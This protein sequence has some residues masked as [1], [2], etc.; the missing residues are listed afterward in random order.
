M[1]NMKAWEAQRRDQCDRCAQRR[2]LHV[3]WPYRRARALW[4]K[5]M[6]AALYDDEKF[7]KEWVGEPLLVLYSGTEPYRVCGP[8]PVCFPELVTA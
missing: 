8:E 2:A 4:D 5:I 1:I 6:Q 7:P 3:P